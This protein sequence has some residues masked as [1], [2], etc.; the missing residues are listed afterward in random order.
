MTAFGVPQPHLSVQPLPFHLATPA[1]TNGTV[2]ESNSSTDGMHE[3]NSPQLP[4]ALQATGFI[5]EIS[6]PLAQLNMHDVNDEAPRAA[7][8][9]PGEV[10]LAAMLMASQIF[11]EH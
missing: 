1:L 3:G 5:P 6:K 10:L 7:Q 8:A 11:S 4:S 9:A 2:H